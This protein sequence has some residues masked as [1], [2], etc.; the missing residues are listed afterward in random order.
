[1]KE[2]RISFGVF[3]KPPTLVGL[4]RVQKFMKESGFQEPF[5]R[6]R[7]C[8]FYSFKGYDHFHEDGGRLEKAIKVNGPN[9]RIWSSMHLSPKDQSYFIDFRSDMFGE[10][11][12]LEIVCG[13]NDETLTFMK[14]NV[15]KIYRL[16][17][18]MAI[19]YRGKTLRNIKKIIVAIILDSLDGLSWSLPRFS[20]W[21]ENVEKQI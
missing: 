10:R 18:S 4:K 14:K 16:S 2:E 3:G 12:M 20:R 9:E 5:V 7:I 15:E 1:M 17:F 13:G 21:E 6:T 8:I 11:E 19:F